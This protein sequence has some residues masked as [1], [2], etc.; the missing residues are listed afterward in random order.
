MAGVAP[1]KPSP[2]NGTDGPAAFKMDAKFRKSFDLE[3]TPE[4][5]PEGKYLHLHNNAALIIVA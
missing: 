4:T 2:R 1:T 3:E 5:N